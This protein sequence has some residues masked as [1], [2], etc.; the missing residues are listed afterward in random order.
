MVLE[1]N[2]AMRR[3]VMRYWRII[4]VEDVSL[5]GILDKVIKVSGIA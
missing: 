3:F 5:A 4:I 2:L 1:A